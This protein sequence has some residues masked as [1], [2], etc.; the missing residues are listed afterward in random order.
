MKY[1]VSGSVKIGKFENFYEK[2]MGEEVPRVQKVVLGLF[3]LLLGGPEVKMM[4]R[5]W[6]VFAYVVRFPG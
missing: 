1:F 6:V 5:S 2:C 4:S 3:A